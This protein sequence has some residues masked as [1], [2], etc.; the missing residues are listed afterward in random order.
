MQQD[1]FTIIKNKTYTITKRKALEIASSLLLDVNDEIKAQKLQ[2]NNSK[3]LIGDIACVVL[4]DLVVTRR[5]I[6]NKDRTTRPDILE[7]FNNKH[8]QHF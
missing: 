8:I 2:V 7:E 4:F 5:Q 1:Y 3:Y 6:I